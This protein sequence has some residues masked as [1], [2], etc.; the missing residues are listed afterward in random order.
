MRMIKSILEKISPVFLPG[1]VVCILWM[2]VATILSAAGVMTPLAD[3]FF[4]LD[5]VEEISV[6]ASVFNIA[7][8][9][10]LL[11]VS[12]SFVVR[13]PWLFEFNLVAILAGLFLTGLLLS[14]AWW[15]FLVRQHEGIP[16]SKHSFWWM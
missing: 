8:P 7:I 15:T 6:A 1:I 2:F 10:C 4:R 9:I 13:S 16:L 3:E 11:I 5:F 14:L 12:L